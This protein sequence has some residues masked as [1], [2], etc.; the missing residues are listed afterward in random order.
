MVVKMA[1]R[2]YGCPGSR[3]RKWLVLALVATNILVVPELAGVNV[4]SD[5][6]S[7]AAGGLGG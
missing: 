1:K 7:V 4:G 2:R 6:S 5:G 3:G